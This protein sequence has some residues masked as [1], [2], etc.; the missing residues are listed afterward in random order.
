M[1]SA[2]VLTV[3]ALAACLA[4]A[5]AAQAQSTKGAGK[6]SLSIIKWP[7]AN[8]QAKAAGSMASKPAASVA[9]K[10][11]TGGASTSVKLA[12]DVSDPLKPGYGAGEY[13][14]DIETG[15][16]PDADVAV[17]AYVTLTVDSL[18]K[19]TVHA[20]ATSADPNQGQCFAA[21]QE[22]ICAP[23]APGKCSFTTYQAAGIPNYTLG[24]GDGQPTASRV[25][26]RTNPDPAHCRTGDILLA[27]SPVPG[28]SV[29]SSG[30]VV[31]IM[32][33]ANGDIDP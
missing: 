2:R 20:A 19:C 15:A 29:C 27:G 14:L 3:A 21:P 6:T 25:R 26:L 1:R 10:P 22:P 32:G 17:H 4:F 12:K 11:P 7:V 30:T 13:V 33:V 23:I 31:G 16:T 8:I 24:P 18:F 9:G 28:D 5:G